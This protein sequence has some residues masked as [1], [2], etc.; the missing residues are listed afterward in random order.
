MVR[1]QRPALC[2][3]AMVDLS[4]GA[5]YV[6]RR[7]RLAHVMV[8]EHVAGANNHCKSPISDACRRIVSCHSEAT[9]VCGQT[10]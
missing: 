10:P 6:T 9:L 8:G 2:A 4:R 1:A 3:A 5:G 7:K